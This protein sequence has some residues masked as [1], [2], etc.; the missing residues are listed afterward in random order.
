MSEYR[1]LA[2]LY[3]PNSSTPIDV[4]GRLLGN[5]KINQAMGDPSQLFATRTGDV[6]VEFDDQDGFISSMLSVDN[7]RRDRWQIELWKDERR[8]FRGFVFPEAIQHD[9]NSGTVTMTGLG[10]KSLLQK[11][12]AAIL[13]RQFF[14]LK[15]AS[16]AAEDAVDVTLSFAGGGAE[17]PQA[18]DVIAF[19]EDSSEYT[20]SSLDSV[21]LA[22]R[23]TEPLASP[24]PA[25]TLVKVLTPYPRNVEMRPL[26]VSLMVGSGVQ[27]TD[28][29][30]EEGFSE[31]PFSTG[32]NSNGL[33]GFG[34]F[35]GAASMTVGGVRAMKAVLSS[36]AYGQSAV[37]QSLSITG[38]F[39]TSAPTGTFG[40]NSPY[41]RHLDVQDYGATFAAGGGALGDPQNPG[42]ETSNFLGYADEWKAVRNGL[43]FDVTSKRFCGWP[44][45]AGAGTGVMFELRVFQRV[46][47][48]RATSTGS[49]TNLVDWLTGGLD[50]YVRLYKWTTAD[51]GATWAV[52]AAFH[53]TGYY[54][55]ASWADP[56]GGTYQPNE[57]DAAVT[58]LPG[59]ASTLQAVE[60]RRD[61]EQDWCISAAPLSGPGGTLYL[62]AMLAPYAEPQIIRAS[63]N[64][65]RT[66]VTLSTIH[67]G[68]GSCRAL[69]VD[70]TSD[71]WLLWKNLP[72]D[73]VGRGLGVDRDR[74]TGVG[75]PPYQATGEAA[76]GFG[77]VGLV[78]RAARWNGLTGLQSRVVIPFASPDGSGVGVG[79]VSLAPL[80][81][82]GAWYS[83]RVEAF[84]I[85]AQPRP[86]LG[87]QKATRPVDLEYCAFWRTST[88]KQVWFLRVAERTLLVTREVT[89]YIAYADFEGL[90]AAE[91]V[92]QCAFLTNSR[93]KVEA[94]DVPIWRG[95]F[96]PAAQ[97]PAKRRVLESFDGSTPNGDL[98][99]SKK[100]TASHEHSYN[101][102]RVTNGLS[103]SD[104]LF[105]QAESGDPA[106][107]QDA[108]EIK[109]I[110]LDSPL[111]AKA[112][113]RKL[114]EFYAGSILLTE[115]ALLAI[116]SATSGS[117]HVVY[118]LVA[119]DAR[120]LPVAISATAS[121][122]TVSMAGFANLA[123]D[124]AAV[125]NAVTAK[126]YAVGGN[127]TT[128]R[129]G[130][131]AEVTWSV[132]LASDTLLNLAIDPNEFPT[133]PVRLGT[134]QSG[135]LVVVDDGYTYE[136]GDEIAL[137]DMFFQIDPDNPADGIS[138]VIESIDT[139]QVGDEIEMSVYQK[140]LL[141]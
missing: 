75:S 128:D 39:E 58:F 93:W 54:E 95:T 28:V 8:T 72:G 106:F 52:D 10:G 134:R 99:L 9:R 107:E 20:L 103:D 53:G 36:D 77:D 135:E 16:D 37:R 76:L 132:G 11:Q 74:Y 81:V 104:P 96:R 61:G 130:L 45:N 83:P 129:L 13:K 60:P 69:H 38:G 4:T 50:G 22:A 59:T 23:L 117:S 92:D 41:G 15:V 94:D 84:E 140:E 21:T 62:T 87:D 5:P 64:A 17:L 25:G 33:S 1:Q 48:T 68:A 57:G 125:P 3:A 123:W 127:F 34:E 108:L 31:T 100:L 46:M 124:V 30:V 44:L 35:R 136:V 133:N 43:W 137:R 71:V 139:E 56:T 115:Q 7:L 85:L 91:A 109:L 131:R 122:G 98:I 63:L 27:G 65:G 101:F 113:A 141:G 82:T 66:L 29:V 126:V 49:G 70:A 32:L 51:S 2:F 105:V 79:W 24:L 114:A 97:M 26:I 55:L 89:G 80:T 90:S 118:R 40:A 112:I 12:T 102:I 119:L 111:Y 88:D 116:T 47:T 110:L 120:G 6:T 19:G 18:G 67:Y 78:M 121:R 86:A 42:P 138:F 14:G 73:G